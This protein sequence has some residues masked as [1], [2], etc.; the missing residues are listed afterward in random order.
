MNKLETAL[1]EIAASRRKA[2][3]ASAW[4]CAESAAEIAGVKVY[5]QEGNN[6]PDLERLERDVR[7]ALGNQTVIVTRHKT[8]VA[9][10]AAHGVT[11]EVIAQA[12]PETVRGKDVYGILP[13]WLAAEANSITEVSM[14]GLPLEARARV[15]GGDFTVEQ[16]DEWGAV[17]QRFTVRRR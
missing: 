8:L 7:S 9:W 16:M 5:G 2:S 3:K 13:M 4:L 14:P 6:Y 1:N 17:M 12:T 11:G 10:L 15:N